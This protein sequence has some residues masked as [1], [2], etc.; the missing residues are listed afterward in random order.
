MWRGEST[1]THRW[2]ISNYIN[3]D[4]NVYLVSKMGN[5]F[6]N[7]KFKIWSENLKSNFN[8]TMI[9]CNG[10]KLTINPKIWKLKKNNTCDHGIITLHHKIFKF[11]KTVAYFWNRLYRENPWLID[12][13]CWEMLRRLWSAEPTVYAGWTLIRKL[14]ISYHCLNDKRFLYQFLVFWYPFQLCCSKLPLML[15]NYSSL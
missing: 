14:K 11:C 2:A 8:S 4:V 9:F 5:R 6:T 1:P 7:R 10:K 13:W 15:R 12:K 3:I